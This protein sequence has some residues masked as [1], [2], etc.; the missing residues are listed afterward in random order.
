MSRTCAPLLLVAVVALALS[1]AGCDASG[2]E[3]TVILNSSSPI[4]PTVEYTFAYD[5]GGQQQIGVTSLNSDTLGAIL[6]RNGFGR[7]DVRSARIERVFLERLSDPGGQSQPQKAADTEVFDYLA[8]ATMYFGGDA[9]TG[10]RVAEKTFGM[11]VRSTPLD[12]VSENA[13]VTD[14]VRAGRQPAYLELEA[15]GSV[16]E[17]RDRIRITV[18]FRVEVQGV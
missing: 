8:T 9:G 18:D 14:A 6:R 2:A 12:V 17:R 3:E 7:N 10:V 16:P 15:T 1:L 11:T 13:D 4:P 5:T